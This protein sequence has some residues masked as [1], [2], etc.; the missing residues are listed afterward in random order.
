[1][2]SA[3][4]LALHPDARPFGNTRSG[5]LKRV[6]ELRVGSIMFNPD[7]M[8]GALPYDADLNLLAGALQFETSI[9]GRGFSAVVLFRNGG[10]YSI[11]LSW[12]E[13]TERAEARLVLNEFAAAITEKYGTPATL[14][15]E[16]GIPAIADTWA[17]PKTRI[18]LAFDSFD[19]GGRQMNAG[20]VV[21]RY[22]VRITYTDATGGNAKG[23]L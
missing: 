16:Y 7:F 11:S 19:V 1:M 23:N 18:G 5:A 3:Q 6:T 4:V 20:D 2:T 14:T 8:A 15:E 10:L 17:L 22:V 9:L 12:R 13:G 21:L